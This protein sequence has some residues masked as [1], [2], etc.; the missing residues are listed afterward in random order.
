MSAF[1]FASA[2][3]KSVPAVADPPSKLRSIV[4][5]AANVTPPVLTV[6]V[7]VPAA[8]AMVAGATLTAHSG[9]SSFTMVTVTSSVAPGNVMNG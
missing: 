5:A 9:T 4:C 2:T 6:T 8:S 1:P 3:V 7:A